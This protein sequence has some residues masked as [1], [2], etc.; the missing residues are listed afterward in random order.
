MSSETTIKLYESARNELI[1]RIGLRDNILLVFLGAVATI[2]GLALSKPDMKEIMLTIPFLS[3]GASVLVSQHNSLI[4][5]L[6]EYCSQEIGKF[7][8]KEYDNEVVSQWDN[9]KALERYSS[10]A[11]TLRTLGHI[12]LLLFPSFISLI[13]NV[14][15]SFDFS[16]R[17]TLVWWICFFTFILSLYYIIDT[18]YWRKN[19][20][21]KIIK[22]RN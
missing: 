18:H 22:W 10:H 13:F 19:I 2:L 17:Y 4:G 3:L 7:L 1:H 12:M 16:L 20:Y 11:M 8:E 15:Y 5:A 9:S 6:G 14:N 21:K